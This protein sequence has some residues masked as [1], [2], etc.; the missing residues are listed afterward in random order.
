MLSRLLHKILFLQSLIIS[1]C[2]FSQAVTVHDFAGWEAVYLQKKLTPNVELYLEHQLRLSQTMSAASRYIFR[3]AVFYFFSPD[4][5]GAL[6]YAWQ[7]TFG[8][9]RNENRIW[10]QITVKKKTEIFQ[11]SNRLRFEQR[12]IGGTDA[13]SFRF[14]NQAKF[15]IPLTQGDRPWA[16]S[17]WDEVFFI[18]HQV[19][20][21]PPSGFDQ[22]RAFL[23][24]HFK[25]TEE[26][27]LEFG[28]M[29]LYDPELVPG[30]TLINHTSVLYAYINI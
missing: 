16:I 2:A 8:L 18:P 25:A 6:G 1:I 29:N 11:W 27:S 5:F 24:L 9:F 7:P 19:T 17:I 26:T 3:P 30:I 23:G 22:N 13:V 28:Y 20:N 14:R 21:G 4:L 15:L 10:Q 12:F